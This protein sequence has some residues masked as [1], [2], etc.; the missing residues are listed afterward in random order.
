[1]KPGLKVSH[2]GELAWTVDPSHT[3]TL[4]LGTPT[5][6]MVFSTPSMIM[7]MERAAREALRPYL[8]TGEETVGIEVS[9]EHLAGAPLGAMVRGVATVTA[10][11]DR[12]IAFDLAAYHGE[13]LLGRGRHTRAV[14]RVERLLENLRKVAP[15]S[16]G[17]MHI[18]SNTGELPAFKT[19]FVTVSA[20]VATVILNR[21]QSLNAIDTVMTADLE[22]LVA[23][24]AGHPED[25]RVV[26]LSGAGPAFST[27]D[28]VKEL[29]TLSL[30]FARELSLRQ[31]QLYLAFESLP[32]PL[33][34]A[35]NGA[36]VG[37]G[38][39]C[40]YSCD[41][42]IASHA[43]SFGMPEIRL[44]W[45]PGYG[46]AQLTALV[47]KAR[48]LEL[49]LTGRTITAREAADWGLVHE[50]VS[51]SMLLERARALAAQLLQMP[52]LALRETKRVIHADEGSQPKIAHRLDTEAY[53]RCLESADAQ[54]GIAAFRDKRQPRFQ[55]R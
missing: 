51:G 32:Q 41:F 23:W 5:P 24:L 20:Q 35:V 48:A 16:G 22:Q 13:R 39:V 10:I 21:P 34:A 37:A 26:I 17:S 9:V 55:G 40:A 7:L 50:V 29:G 42:R 43:A 31:A 8:D 38:C 47:G 6:V 33:I 52:A 12:R 28:D 53:I 2:Q 44:G 36:A 49:C 54:E 18:R 11:E 27:G 30:E 19:L 15:N 1:M 25:I 4:G 14:A 45:T 3:I 46:I